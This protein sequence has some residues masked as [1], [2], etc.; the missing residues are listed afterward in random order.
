MT[1]IL[2]RAVG[3]QAAERGLK[4]CGAAGALGLAGVLALAIALGGGIR[5]R[6][7]IQ[8]GANGSGGGIRGGGGHSDA[9][10]NDDDF[11]P[12][13]AERR[14]RALNVERQKQLV[15]DTNKLLKLAKELNDEVAA[16]SSN[17]FTAEQLRKIGEIEKLAK[18]V[19]ERMTQGV[20]EG[21]NTL[22]APALVYPGRQGP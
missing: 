11:D 5:V 9:L 17:S 16:T 15:A 6:A 7:Q 14:L 22:P 1:Q 10:T 4:R 3:A 12:V 13:M 20:G 2:V 19:R 18:S 8:P 21:Q